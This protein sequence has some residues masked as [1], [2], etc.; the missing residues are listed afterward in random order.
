MQTIPTTLPANWRNII[1]AS[2][3][4][5]PKPVALMQAIAMIRGAGTAGLPADV[6]RNCFR[7]MRKPIASGNIL[8]S[9]L[10]DAGVLARRKGKGWW[11]YIPDFI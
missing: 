4:A 7:F 5:N 8:P 6:L 10:A 3:P 11:Y 1:P 9:E 2:L